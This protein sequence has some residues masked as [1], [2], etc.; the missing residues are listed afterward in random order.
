M[1]EGEL[2]LLGQPCEQTPSRTPV[3]IGL[4]LLSIAVDGQQSHPHMSSTRSPPDV[5]GRYLWLTSTV[6][7]VSSGG[8]V[9]EMEG[10]SNSA[11]APPWTSDPSSPKVG[12]RNWSAV[13]VRMLFQG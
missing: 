9:S 6:K 2:Y 5:G 4:P 7:R 3:L 11:E 1:Q 8:N 10:I 12:K 13:E